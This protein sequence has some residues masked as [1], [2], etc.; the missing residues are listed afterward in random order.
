MPSRDHIDRRTLL[1]GGAALSAWPLIDVPSAF[2]E[3]AVGNFPAGVS[4]STAF[5]G[6]TIPLTGPYSAEG[7]DMLMGYLL[8][9]DHL[10]N[11]GVL[12][13]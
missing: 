12:V 6:L 5:V 7:D 8:G 4:G 10:N 2:A 1:K 13:G 9:I 11:G 3:D